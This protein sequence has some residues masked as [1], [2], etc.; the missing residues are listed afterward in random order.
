MNLEGLDL[1]STRPV[2]SAAQGNWRE[3]NEVVRP[4]YYYF[5]CRFTITI[6]TDCKVNI[7]LIPKVKLS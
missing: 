7:E 1:D 5:D 4:G 6:I 3:C 2:E